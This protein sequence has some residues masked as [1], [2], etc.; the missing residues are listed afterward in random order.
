MS[1]PDCQPTPSSNPTTPLPSFATPALDGRVWQPRAAPLL[2]FPTS[3]PLLIDTHIRWLQYTSIRVRFRSHI[4]VGGVILCITD[5][6]PVVNS[7]GFLLQQSCEYGNPLCKPR[8][9]GI[10]APWLTDYCTNS[11]FLSITQYARL[12]LS[13]TISPRMPSGIAAVPGSRELPL[14]PSR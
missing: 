5:Y 6:Q 7:S 4:S 2:G 3:A 1:K 10:N 14:S 11:P 9:Q 8:H 12:Q 13:P